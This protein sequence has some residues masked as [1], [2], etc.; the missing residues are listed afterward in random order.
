MSI[1]QKREIPESELISG[2]IEGKRTHQE[3][4]YRK[5]SPVMFAICL[6]YSGDYHFAEDLLQEGFLK[7]FQNIS[8]YRNAGSF[9]GWMKRV[10]INHSIEVLRK[11][12][13]LNETKDIEPLSWQFSH[14]PIMPQLHAADLIKMIQS[15]PTGYRTIFNLYVVEGYAHNEIGDMLGI[16]EGTSKSQLSRAR[17]HLQKMIEQSEKLPSPEKSFPYE[18]SFG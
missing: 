12:V 13:V 14:D 11:R 6:R 9:E 8:Q 16:S 17:V 15:L 18:P 1:W 5:Y 2:C 10:F 4:L 3:F 7:V